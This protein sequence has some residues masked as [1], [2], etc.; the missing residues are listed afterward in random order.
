MC[1]CPISK[2]PLAT[3][4]CSKF[5]HHLLRDV[6]VVFRSSRFWISS[7]WVQ[8]PPMGSPLEVFW[9]G[10]QGWVQLPHVGIACS[11]GIRGCQAC[12]GYQRFQLCFAFGCCGTSSQMPGRSRCVRHVRVL[13]PSQQPSNHFTA[14]FCCGPEVLCGL[15]EYLLAERGDLLVERFASD[16]LERCHTV[17]TDMECRQCPAARLASHLKVELSSPIVAP[18]CHSV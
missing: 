12:R 2:A 4:C 8:P 14:S 17:T 7:L 9:L 16:A 6:D 13:N 15:I 1:G 5:R 11:R 3:Q 10:P 18:I